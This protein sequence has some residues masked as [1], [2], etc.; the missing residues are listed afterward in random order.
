[1]EPQK[2]AEIPGIC[3]SSAAAMPDVQLSAKTNLALIFCNFW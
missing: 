2:Q 3:P 1:M